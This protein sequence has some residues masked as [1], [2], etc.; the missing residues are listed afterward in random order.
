MPASKHSC[1]AHLI[2][3]GCGPTGVAGLVQAAIEGI[4]AFGIEAGPAPLASVLEY[5]EGLLLASPAFHFEV[6][7]L[8][9]DCRA[10]RDVRRE[11]LL[12]YYGR[13]ISYFGLEIR[14]ST[15]CVA[16][17]PRGDHIEIFVETQG[18][19]GLLRAQRVLITSWYE[20]RPPSLACIA[21]GHEVL[22]CAGIRNP[23]EVAGKN[24]VIV[25]GGLS[26]YEYA[27]RLLLMGQ[28]IVFLARSDLR[29]EPPPFRRLLRATGS[30]AWYGVSSI[31]VVGSTVEFTEGELKHRE[32]CD[33]LI[34]ALGSRIREDVVQML[35]TVGVLTEH[36]ANLIR[37]AKSYE[38]LAREFPQEHS[39]SLIRRAVAELPDLRQQLFQGI[40]GIHVAGGA[41]H[42]GAAN[43]GV[44]TSIV[45]AQLAVRAMAGHSPPEGSN[46]PLPLFLNTLTLPEKLPPAIAF[47][48]VAALLPVRSRECL[49]AVDSHNAA[50][51]PK[52][53]A[54]VDANDQMLSCPEAAS[55]SPEAAAILSNVDGARSVAEL[56]RHFGVR[57]VAEK[58]RFRR[59]LRLMWWSGALSWLPPA[60]RPGS[61]GW[62]GALGRLQDPTPNLVEH[63]PR[64]LVEADGSRIACDLSTRRGLDRRKERRDTSR[65]PR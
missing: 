29:Y 15:R 9:L 58:E 50:S 13:V 51:Q 12:Y 24:V 38:K 36:E 22:L 32:P 57:S 61:P 8:P 11:D 56:A 16:I 65:S 18:K 30:S 40:R 27:N 39:V 5:M 4:P 26:A 41:L 19:P 47:Q 25:G 62:I 43:A 52:L 49:G 59:L 2:V 37:R 46:E 53:G 64:V 28:R 7:G 44:K 3:V 35:S 60:G 23:I 34:A 33:V 14:S 55:E 45:T 6:G 31:G 48:R 17:R 63:E 1:D 21:Q 10:V 20:R 54:T 42:A